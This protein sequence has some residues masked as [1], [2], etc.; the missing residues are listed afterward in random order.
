VISQ[1]RRNDIGGTYSGGTVFRS[2][3]EEFFEFMSA[4][5]RVGGLK[6]EVS[7][8]SLLF[9]AHQIVSVFPSKMRKIHHLAGSHAVTAERSPLLHRFLHN[10]F[11]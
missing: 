4:R 7:A 10:E 3:V 8:A 1:K 9:V 11:A 5:Y 2:V 6:I